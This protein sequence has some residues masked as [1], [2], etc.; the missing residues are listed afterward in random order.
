MQSLFKMLEIKVTSKF[1]AFQLVYLGVHIHPQYY[2]QYLQYVYVRLCI[3]IYIDRTHY[4]VSKWKICIPIYI[5]IHI[6]MYMYKYIYIY[7][8]HLYI[9]SIYIYVDRY[10]HHTC[11]IYNVIFVSC[12]LY[13]WQHPMDRRRSYWL[14]EPWLSSTSKAWARGVFFRRFGKIQGT[15]GFSHGFPCFFHGN[16]DT[17]TGVLVDVP[18]SSMRIVGVEVQV[19]CFFPFVCGLSVV[20]TAWM[21]QIYLCTAHFHVLLEE[22]DLTME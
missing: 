3:Y 17:K 18:T 12:I 2:I 19:G 14:K 6:Y 5:Y 8:I 21:G 22:H 20:D 10:I 9:C 7:H 16:M 4:Y 15:P 11:Y 1:P 13:F